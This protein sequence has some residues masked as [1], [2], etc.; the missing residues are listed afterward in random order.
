MVHAVA[1]VLLPDGDDAVL[2]RLHVIHEDLVAAC[3][4]ILPEVGPVLHR[5]ALRRLRPLLRVLD[6]LREAQV[7]LER[8]R[9]AEA[10]ALGGRPRSLLAVAHPLL[11]HDA[12][13]LY[14]G[15][16]RSWLTDEQ[17]RSYMSPAGWAACERCGGADWGLSCT[18]P[19]VSRGRL[20]RD[21]LAECVAFCWSCAARRPLADD[22]DV[23]AFVCAASARGPAT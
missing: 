20:R 19:R 10:T 17:P 8:C 3:E 18:P 11:F 23:T 14:A 6:S 13:T 2:A 4:G 22:L 15:L 7:D 16:L 9:A 1:L 12:C 5:L 21:P